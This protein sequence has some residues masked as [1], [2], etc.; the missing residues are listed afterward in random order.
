MKFNHNDL[1]PGAF[2]VGTCGTSVRLP[3]ADSLLS[4]E[5]HERLPQTNP[6]DFHLRAPWSAL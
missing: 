4:P 2:S 3:T 6:S 5:Y 1:G